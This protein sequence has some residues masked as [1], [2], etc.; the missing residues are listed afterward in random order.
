VQQPVPPYRKR[1]RSLDVRYLRAW[2]VAFLVFLLASSGFAHGLM[3]DHAGTAAS[4]PH[5]VASVG[6]DLDGSPCCPG[7]DGD[8][9]ARLCGVASAC[10][11]CAPASAPI[12]LARADVEP[13]FA[14]PESIPPGRSLTPHLRPPKTLLIV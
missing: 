2:L 8:L 7:H 11:M 5:G 6:Q 1:P 9:Q 3:A 12:V 4:L 13:A 10:G 14:M